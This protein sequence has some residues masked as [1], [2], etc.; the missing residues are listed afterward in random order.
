VPR[1]ESVSV[2]AE[3]LERRARPDMMLTL[4]DG[5]K[6]GREHKLESLETVQETDDGEVF[7]T[8]REAQILTADWRRL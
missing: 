7:Y 8:L 2:Q 6:V 4:E 1:I 5:R 3:Y